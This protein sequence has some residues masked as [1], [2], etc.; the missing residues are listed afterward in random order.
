M[1]DKHRFSSLMDDLGIVYDKAVSADLKRLY[2]D[3]LGQL[4]IDV[5]EQAITAH[6]RDP[7]RGRF[8]PKPADIL[9]ACRDPRLRHP[10][11][12]VAWAICL[13]SLDE[14]ASVTLTEQIGQARAAALPVWQA[15]DKVGARM[16][17]KAAY[18]RLAGAG[19]EPPRWRFSPGH[20]AA[21]R[22]EAA[23]QALEQ[24][25]L[26]REQLQRYLPAPVTPEGEALAGL[27]TGRVV[28]HPANRDADARA[29]LEGLRQTIAAAA[30]GVDA[31]RE[32]RDR[33]RDADAR[34][35]HKRRHGTS[36]AEH[37]AALTAELERRKQEGGA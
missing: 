9:G 7:D 13:E 8:F 10:P 33:Q 11:V 26:P 5:I 21:R 37:S 3:D 31:K 32:A 30:A 18:E 2:W 23:E 22:A 17:F 14:A 27:L 16:A 24:G 36:L 28:E 6:R 35:R 12:D 19:A 15:G 34:A 4:P 20:D 25:L 29:R 1:S